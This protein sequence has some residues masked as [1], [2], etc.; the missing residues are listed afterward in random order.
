MKSPPSDF[1]TLVIGAGAAGLAAAAELSLAGQTVCV[2]EARDRI[3]GRIFTR[4]EPELA[5]PLELGAEFIHGLSPM[6][7]SW[8]RRANALVA[9]TAPEHWRMQDG[10]LGSTDDVFEE[11]QRGLSKI[12]KPAKD[13]PFSEFLEGPAK[14]KLSPRAREFAR[15]LVQGFDAA[16]ASRVSTLKTLEEWSGGSAADAPTFRPLGGYGPLLSALQGALDQQQVRTLLNSVVHEVHWRRGAVL[17]EGIRYGLPF[18]I[19]ARRVIVTLPLGVLQLPAQ[20]PGAV[21]FT[22]ALK[23]KQKA[24]TGLAAGPVVK[25][26]LKFHKAFWEELENARYRDA[27]F[28][29]SPQAPFPT[30]WTSLPLRSPL[31]VAWAAGPNAARLSGMPEPEVVQLALESLTLL[32]GKRPNVRDLLRSAHL[33]DW[34]SDPFAYGAYSYVVAGGSAARKQLAA[35]VQD[36]LFFA[37]EAADISGAAATVEGALQSGKRAAQSVL[38]AGIT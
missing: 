10:K 18:S 38:A 6:T 22:P 29:H 2:L 14:G 36:T 37:G 4:H 24:L 25:V 8:L 5:A 23:T 11:M 9:D 31:L 3:G 15:T 12:R 32:F 16:D 34:Q 26:M 19:K 17:V 35:P 30:F 1:D 27:A 33:H 13:L 28:F 20:A 7:M 21:H